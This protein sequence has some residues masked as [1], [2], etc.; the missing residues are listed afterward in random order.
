VR[1]RQILFVALLLYVTLDLCVPLVGG[2]FVFEAADSVESV[3]V[4]RTRAAPVFVVMPRLPEVGPE[5]PARA[6]G[7]DNPA[8]PPRAPSPAFRV[9]H[10][11]PRAALSPSRPSPDH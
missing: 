1:L 9:V 2:A 4:A 3:Q 11:R 6:R 7:V 5:E 8:A 10:H